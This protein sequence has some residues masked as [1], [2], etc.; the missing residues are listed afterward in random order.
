M[1]AQ[2]FFHNTD[3][4][5]VLLFGHSMFL[6]QY[7]SMRQYLQFDNTIPEINWHDIRIKKI[8][9]YSKYIYSNK[10]IN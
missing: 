2:H 6:H 1:L 10:K 5:A 8:K 3:P 7:Q 4:V 9:I